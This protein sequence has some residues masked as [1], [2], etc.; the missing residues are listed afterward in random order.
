MNVTFSEVAYNAQTDTTKSGWQVIEG[1]PQTFDL[2]TLAN[3]VTAVLGEQELDP[4]R[5][6][7][8]RLKLTNAEVTVDGVVYPLDVPS[9]STSGLKLGGGFTIEE[10]IK[11]EI[12]IDFDA[13]RSIHTTGKKGEY[14]LMPL[15]RLAAKAT[16]GSI[17]GQVTN[18]QNLPIAYAIAGTDTVTSSRVGK[19]SGRFVL[20]FLPSGTYTVAVADTLNKAFVK[21]GVAVTIGNTTNL[22]DITLQ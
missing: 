20:G 14:K 2:L 15:L 16:T 1:E 18:Y 5:Y 6:G 22:G 11:T 12:V 13:A 17:T 21:T 19:E 9:G 4:G 10:G 7:Q 3:G 8:I